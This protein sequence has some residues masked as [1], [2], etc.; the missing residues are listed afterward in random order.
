MFILRLLSKE[1]NL[2]IFFRR[3]TRNVEIQNFAETF[4]SK[5]LDSQVFSQAREVAAVIPQGVPVSTYFFSFPPQQLSHSLPL[6]EQ[7]RGL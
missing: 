7:I 1:L 4:P 2:S 3:D 5:F 6:S